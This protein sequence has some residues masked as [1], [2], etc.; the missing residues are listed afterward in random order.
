MQ[1]ANP[2]DG[3]HE[4]VKAKARACGLESWLACS[5]EGGVGRFEGIGPTGQKKELL[6]LFFIFFY[7][8]PFPFLIFFIQ[9][10]NSKLNVTCTHIT[11]VN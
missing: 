1:E 3:P 2:T 9:V 4:P 10:L 7:N 8:S 6:F 5:R 11:C